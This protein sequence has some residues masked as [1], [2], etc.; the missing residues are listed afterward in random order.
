MYKS[1]LYSCREQI[2][3]VLLKYTTVLLIL[4]KMI[5]EPVTPVGQNKSFFIVWISIVCLHYCMH[6]ELHLRCFHFMCLSVCTGCWA[7]VDVVLKLV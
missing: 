3:K 1:G 5:I 4:M 6:V 2:S 7:R